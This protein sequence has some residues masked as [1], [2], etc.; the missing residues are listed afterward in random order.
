[1]TKP[2]RQP[3]SY[4]TPG[5]FHTDSLYLAA[6]LVAHGMWLST[7]ETD[8]WGRHRFGFKDAAERM[9]LVRQFQIGPKALVDARTFM[10][11]I[12]ELKD[13]AN[14]VHRDVR[15]DD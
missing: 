12:E 11:A 1:M 7:A 14:R 2:D 6:F 5:T 15:Y 10:Y 9:Q 3:S 4:T 8:A 13:R